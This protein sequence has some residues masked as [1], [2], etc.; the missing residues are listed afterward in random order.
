MRGAE[1][2]EQPE[3]Q[4]PAEP[5]GATGECVHKNTNQE[6]AYRPQG[7]V[8]RTPSLLHWALENK[9]GYQ[10]LQDA[11]VHR[12]ARPTIVTMINIVIL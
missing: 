6:Q 1:E 11:Q 2:Q 7:H 5:T 10:P 8:H 4:E 3:G 9:W 12:Q